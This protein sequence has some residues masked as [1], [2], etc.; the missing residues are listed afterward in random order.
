[1]PL[2]VIHCIDDPKAEGVRRA[3][4]DAHLAYL[5]DLGDRLHAAGPTLADDGETMNGSV[6]VAEF[7]DKDAARAWAET[8]PYKRAGLFEAVTIQQW[9][10]VLPAA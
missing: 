3:N 6:I 5:G 10:K 9:K 4:R 7:D 2:Y 8:D 1:M